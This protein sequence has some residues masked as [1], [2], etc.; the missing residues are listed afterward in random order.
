MLGRMVLLPPQD[1][2]PQLQRVNHVAIAQIGGCPV[3]AGRLI[4]CREPPAGSNWSISR[5][6]RVQGEPEPDPQKP[7]SAIEGTR[8]FRGPFRTDQK[9]K[10]GN[11]KEIEWS[12]TVP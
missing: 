12:E 9:K 6:T 1:E 2:L 11:V 4:G 7:V 5:S 10:R 3:N 8:G